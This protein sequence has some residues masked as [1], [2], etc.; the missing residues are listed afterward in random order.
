MVWDEFKSQSGQG[1]PQGTALSCDTLS[2]RALGV[3]CWQIWQVLTLRDSPKLNRQSSSSLV[4]IIFVLYLEHF[5][6]Q[7]LCHHNFGTASSLPKRKQ[8]KVGQLV[9]PHPVKNIPEEMKQE[10]LQTE[11][12]HSCLASQN[13]PQF[14]PSK[15]SKT[16]TKSKQSLD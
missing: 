5:K 3:K 13:S 8:F 15:T 1:I 2:D 10:T 7:C 14:Y 4:C 16:E 9:S 6:K 11:R 12:A